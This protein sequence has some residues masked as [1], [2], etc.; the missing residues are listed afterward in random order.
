MRFSVNSANKKAQ[1]RKLIEVSM[2]LEAINTSSA[3]EQDNPFWKGHPR[4]LHPWWARRPLAACRS[5]LFAQLVDDPSCYPD[6]FPTNLAQETERKRLHHLIE[7]IA[8]WEASA[9]N[10]VLQEA[11]WEIARSIARRRKLPL[12]NAANRQEV[13]QFIQSNGPVVVDPFCGRGTIPLEA[14]RLGLRA[15]G[16]DINPVAV[17]ISK[18]LSEFPAKFAAQPPI[19]PDYVKA[20]NHGGSWQG[21][22]ADGLAEDI[23]YFANKVLSDSKKELERYYPKARTPDGRYLDVVSWIWARTVASPDPSVG[24]AK[25]PLVST[26]MLSNKKREKSLASS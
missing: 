24:G 16:S 15:A 6:E 3:K 19:N 12:P 25:V 10:D 4:S 26:F 21:K 22:G 1:L 23:L 13:I 9:D 20:I 7:R 2:P 18:A 8:P 5:V 11:R 14:Q 17:L